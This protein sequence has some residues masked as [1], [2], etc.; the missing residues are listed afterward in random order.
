MWNNY[1]NALPWIEKRNETLLLVWGWM[2]A[3]SGKM[4]AC[5]WN[6]KRQ[7]INSVA[8]RLRAPLCLIQSAWQIEA[9]NAVDQHQLTWAAYLLTNA[10]LYVGWLFCET[11]QVHTPLKVN[12]TERATFKLASHAEL[13]ESH[14]IIF[15]FIS[16]SCSNNQFSLAIS[17]SSIKASRNQTTSRWFH[18]SNLTI[19]DEMTLGRVRY[20]KPVRLSQNRVIDSLCGRDRPPFFVIDSTWRNWHSSSFRSPCD[21]ATTCDEDTA[22]AR[23]TKGSFT[24]TIFFACRQTIPHQMCFVVVDWPGTNN[25]IAVGWNMYVTRFL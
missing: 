5:A 11:L 19:G 9:T 2:F 14:F 13:W 21:P 24:R 17:H 4:S 3:L 6:E 25:I 16:E 8:R 7:W 12:E 15:I 1:S 10:R 23:T 22:L 20:R 18:N